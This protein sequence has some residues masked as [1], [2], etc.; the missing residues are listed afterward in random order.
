MQS[1]V[2]VSGAIEGHEPGVFLQGIYEGNFPPNTYD[3]L[4]RDS[5][6]VETENFLSSADDIDW[7]R[8]QELHPGDILRVRS[9]CNVGLKAV[10]VDESGRIFISNNEAQPGSNFNLEIKSDCDTRLFIMVKGSVDKKLKEPADYKI[11][12]AYD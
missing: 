4:T 9:E 10:V 5:C 6:E 11:V 1:E 7:Y 12:W 8:T 3:V 2:L